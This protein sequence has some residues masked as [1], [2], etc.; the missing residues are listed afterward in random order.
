MSFFLKQLHRSQKA[1]W[2]RHNLVYI[3]PLFS[4]TTIADSVNANMT[5]KMSGQL[6]VNHSADKCE[7]FIKLT[8]GIAYYSV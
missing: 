1:L 7:F 3:T 2:N 8:E 4:K 6:N 5:Q